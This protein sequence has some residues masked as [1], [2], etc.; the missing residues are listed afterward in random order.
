MIGQFNICEEDYI[1]SAKSDQVKEIAKA[2]QEIDCEKYLN[3][4]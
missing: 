1:A 3:K 4:L 2:L